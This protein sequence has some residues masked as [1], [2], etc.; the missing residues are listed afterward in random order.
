MSNERNYS[1]RKIKEIVTNSDISENDVSRMMT[2][3]RNV[4]EC[5]NERDNYRM[6]YFYCNWASHSLIDRDDV[7]YS[8]LDGINIGFS[9][10]LIPESETSKKHK[11]YGDI[12][13]ESIAFEKL[14]ENLKSFFAESG[15][16]YIP[17]KRIISLMCRNVLEKKVTYPKKNNERIKLR[18][19]KIQNNK[20]YLNEVV[21]YSN[22]RLD[23][24][25]DY[26]KA[27]VINS[28]KFIEV[29]ENRVTCFFEIEGEKQLQSISNIWIK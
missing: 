20:N 10:L 25:I 22:P 19:E 1:L 11:D 17:Y 26:S 21:K 7:L 9:E 2:E 3:M 6:L 24:K 23:P 4:L 16:K 12:I 14:E 28:F 5:D 18:S 8:I 13:A 27:Y 15:I 29:E